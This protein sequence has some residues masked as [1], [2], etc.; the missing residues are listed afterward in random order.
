MELFAAATALSI[1]AVLVLT[2]IAK[3]IPVEF[4]TKYP[5]WVNGILSL[6][7]ALIVVQP[8]F[9]FVDLGTLVGQVLLVSVV[10][11]LAYNQ[12]TSRLK[13]SKV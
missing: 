12:W 2:E 7:A 10:A 1:T 11:A 8:S 5:A 3:V 13:K 9:T 4:T 6:I